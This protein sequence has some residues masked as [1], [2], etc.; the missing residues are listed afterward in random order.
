V[1]GTIEKQIREGEEEALVRVNQ[2]L[3]QVQ[4]VQQLTKRWFQ[5]SKLIE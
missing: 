5:R 3:P 2:V 1:T 4:K